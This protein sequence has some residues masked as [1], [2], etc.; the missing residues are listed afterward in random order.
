[1]SNI[2]DSEVVGGTNNAVQI[3]GMPVNL[4][5]MSVL[6][7]VQKT[8]TGGGNLGYVWAN[9]TSTA[10]QGGMRTILEQS[11]G[12]P[13]PVTGIGSSGTPNQPAMSGTPASVADGGGKLADNTWQHVF[14]YVER[15]LTPTSF[16]LKVDGTA[17]VYDGSASS[18]GSG[19]NVD[20]TGREWMLFN[21]GPWGGALGR[22]L[23][24]N[25][26]YVAVYRELTDVQE[27]SA[28]ANGP[29]TTVNGVYDELYFVY[30]NG[31]L[32]L[33][34][35]GTGIAIGNRTT[36]I[37][38]SAPP[39]V[40]L[41][42]SSDTTPPTLTSTTSAAT[43]STTGTGGVTTNEANGTLYAV[44]TT[45]ATA[46]TG[47]QVRAGQD[48]TGASAPGGSGNQAV[49]STGAKTFN[50][51]S[52]TPSTTYWFHF[53]HR[54]AAGNDSSVVSSASFTTSAAGDTTPPT[55]SSPTGAQTG[56]TTGTG[57]ATTNEA[58][59]T[60]YVVASTSATAP[61][62]AQVKAGQ[63]HTGAAAAASGSVA[64][65]STGA[66]SV[67][68]TG[69]TPSTT[70]YAHAMHE[71]ASGNQSSVV[72]S[73]SFTTPAAAGRVSLLLLILGRNNNV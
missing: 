63:M 45:S 64:V 68:F 57:G 54:D 17:C 3:T 36:R 48:H 55:L 10:S 42:D 47:A 62:A 40:A 28:R 61:S 58:N 73:A 34:P 19:S 66:K 14:F 72:S 37:T 69:L 39:N 5:K 31:Q 44:C 1:M 2:L 9:N 26:A 71:D 21:R 32:Y 53:Q 46:P 30:A 33:G 67:N 22:Q 18:S 24:A 65:S 35:L 70:Y 4:A 60:M 56:S 13:R 49:T 25:V 15:A 8:G 41:G 52:L 20:E 38:T 29:L 51:T 27:A 59:G 6:T 23:Q 11:A 50:A 7:Y 12:G 16:K 43:G